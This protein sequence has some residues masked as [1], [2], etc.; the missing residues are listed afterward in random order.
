MIRSALLS[1]LTVFLIL[2]APSSPTSSI[3]AVSMITTGPTGR[4]SMDLKTGSVVVPGTLETMATSWL[5][6]ALMRL[7]F[8]VLRLP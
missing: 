2:S 3:P 6:R 1:T 5:V 8:P 4:I 7:D